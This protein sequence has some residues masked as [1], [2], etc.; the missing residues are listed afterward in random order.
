M[1]AQALGRERSLGA[2]AL[3]H[4]GGAIVQSWQSAAERPGSVAQRGSAVCLRRHS[5]WAGSVKKAAKAAF[6]MFFDSFYFSI[7]RMYLAPIMT[8][9]RPAS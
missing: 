6:L 7:S 4:P 5:A 3:R 1:T 8:P 2:E 9:S